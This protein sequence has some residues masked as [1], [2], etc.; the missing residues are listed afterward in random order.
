MP[1]CG[2]K[3]EVYSRVVGYLRPVHNWNAGKKEEFRL[4]K[5]FSEGKALA[6]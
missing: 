2:K 6:K 4:R 1:E 5:T 3:T